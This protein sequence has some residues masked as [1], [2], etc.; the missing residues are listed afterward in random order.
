MVSIVFCIGKTFRG[1]DNN[2]RRGYLLNPLC[3][4]VE[5][6]VAASVLDLCGILVLALLRACD[7][8]DSALGKLTSFE[9]IYK[10]SY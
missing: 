5:T 8:S 4:F 3:D 1:S 2:S 7:K 6:G 10:N 9:F